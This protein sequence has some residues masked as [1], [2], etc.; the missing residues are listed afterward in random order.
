MA[1]RKPK[2][3]LML[4]SSVYGREPLIEQIDA[5]LSGFG[6]TV[7]N[8]HLG[9][10]PIL[11]GKSTYESCLIAVERCDIFVCLISPRYGSGTDGAGGKAIT[12]LELERSIALNKPRFIL[13]HEQVINARR[14]VSDLS[15]KAEAR[16]SDANGKLPELSFKGPEGRRDLKLRKGADVIDDL[17]LIEMY[18]AATLEGVPIPERKSNWVQKYQTDRDVHRFIEAQ[19]AAVDEMRA[20]IKANRPEAQE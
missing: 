2:P 18:E 12:H 4:S 17:R 6:Y 15:L 9:T 1:P 14:L 20:L 11:P 16:G 19:F 5:A 7:W 10:L 13:A 3:I 8:S